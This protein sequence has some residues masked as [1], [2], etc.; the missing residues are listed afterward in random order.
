MTDTTMPEIRTLQYRRGDEENLIRVA[1]GP[2]SQ[3]ESGY[4]CP[5]VV[6]GLKQEYKGTLFGNN[7]EQAQR[8]ATHFV[9]SMLP[10]WSDGASLTVIE[11]E[12]PPVVRE[13]TK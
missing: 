13:D 3:S 12:K 1:I 11:T 7:R 4:A 5:Y 10:F 8:L 9:E 2:V 6:S